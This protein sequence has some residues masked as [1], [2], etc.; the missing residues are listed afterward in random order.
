MLLRRGQ[1][2][3]MFL[4]PPEEHERH[5]SVSPAFGAVL[6]ITALVT[7]LWAFFR[8]DHRLGVRFGPRAVGG[9]ALERRSR[10]VSE[11]KSIRRRR[12]HRESRGRQLLGDFNSS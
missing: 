7:V 3:D 6:G 8:P 9:F 12:V 4:T 10:I 11:E 2:H 5:V 1:K